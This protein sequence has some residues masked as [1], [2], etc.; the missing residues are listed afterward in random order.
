M[1]EKKVGDQNQPITQEELSKHK[2]LES[3][4]CSLNGIVYDVTVYINYHPGGKILLD[5]CGK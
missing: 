4:W 2:I 3:A 1:A 5:G